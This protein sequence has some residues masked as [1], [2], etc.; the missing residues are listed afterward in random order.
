MGWEGRLHRYPYPSVSRLAIYTDRH[1][2]L[3]EPNLNNQVRRHDSCDNKPRLHHWQ[4]IT[5]LTYQRSGRTPEDTQEHL[6]AHWYK[7]SLKYNIR[8]G[9]LHC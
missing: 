6:L 8:L 3:S 2:M 4:D 7:H 1:F 9:I 5:E